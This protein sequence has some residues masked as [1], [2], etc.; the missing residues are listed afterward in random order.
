MKI[1]TNKK[2][3]S[4]II[5]VLIFVLLFQFVVTKPT[6]ANADFALEMGGK[7][8]SPILSLGVRLSQ[9]VMKKSNLFKLCI[10]NII[11]FHNQF[12]S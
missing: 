7:L 11:T 4:K 1:F 8:L 3:W 12:P 2:I 10:N 5:I 6:L 9:I